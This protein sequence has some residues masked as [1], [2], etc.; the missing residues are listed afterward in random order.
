[1]TP[2]ILFTHKAKEDDLTTVR[3]AQ[4][5]HHNTPADM[6]AY[7]VYKAA[8]RFLKA[9]Q[10][11]FVKIVSDHFQPDIVTKELGLALMQKALPEIE[12]IAGSMQHLAYEP[13]HFD[14]AELQ[15]MQAINEFL[16]KSQGS[17]FEDA[18][19]YYRLQKRRPMPKMFYAIPDSSHKQER[20]E[21]FEQLIR[22][23]TL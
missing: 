17:A 11:A 23:L 20:R 8:S 12:R 19:R 10:M 21:Y 14:D 5:T 13:K 22:A 6:E 4:A 9:H 15:Q 1:L 16:T 2:D 3:S 7:A 18:C